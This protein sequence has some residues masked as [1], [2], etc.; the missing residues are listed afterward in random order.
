MGYQYILVEKRDGVL[1]ITM[2]RPEKHNPLNQTVIEEILGAAKE[3]EADREIGPIVLKGAGRSFCSGFDLTPQPGRVAAGEKSIRDDINDMTKASGRLGELWN[4]TKP[5]IAQVQGYCLAGGTDLAMHCDMIVCSEDAQFGFPAVRSMGA[6]PTHMWTY[7]VGPQWAKRMLLTGDM[8]DGKTAERI[9]L[10]LK[11]VPLAQLDAEVH[12]I[13]NNMAAIPYE[14]LAANKSICNKAV[15]AMGRTLVQQMALEVDAI[16][17]RAQATIDFSHKM[18]AKG[19]K[20][21][22]QERDAKF[23]K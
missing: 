6:P 14:L 1:T 2:N 4:L 16:A 17:H 23:V 5:V 8:I 21:A 10:A 12:K 19:V 15:E 11:A 20:A 7:H 9:G 22:L 3:A 18:K 13:A